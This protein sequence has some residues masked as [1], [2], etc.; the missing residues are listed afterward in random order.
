V[1]SSH[2]PEPTLSV[3][4]EGDYLANIRSLIL[5]RRGHFDARALAADASV[6]AVLLLGPLYLLCRAGRGTAPVPVWP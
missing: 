1:L 5:S 4:E 3:A 6:D 2:R